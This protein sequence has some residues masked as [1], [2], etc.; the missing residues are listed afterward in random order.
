MCDSIVVMH[1]GR[2]VE[3]GPV[4]DVYARP[5]HEYTRKLLAAVP[6]RQWSRDNEAA[7]GTP[8]TA[9]P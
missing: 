8:P 9:A 5:T 1:Q 4:A 2:V 6:G 3:T 7:A